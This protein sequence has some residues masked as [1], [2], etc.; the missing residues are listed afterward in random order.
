MSLKTIITNND[1]ENSEN[2]QEIVKYLM[3][4]YEQLGLSNAT[5]YYK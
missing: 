1:Y 3:S 2:V 4:N 5:L